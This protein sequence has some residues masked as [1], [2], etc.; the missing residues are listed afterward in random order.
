MPSFRLIS[1]RIISSALTTRPF[2]HRFFSVKLAARSVLLLLALLSAH[3][4]A[5]VTIASGNV[6]DVGKY[7]YRTVSGLT[8]PYNDTAMCWAAAASNVIQYWQ[9][10]YGR[11]AAPDTPQGANATVYT[12]PAG[13]GALEVYN[14]LLQNWTNSSGHPYNGFTW[15]MQGGGLYDKNSYSKPTAGTA[16]GGYYQ[17]I[18]GSV[19]PDHGSDTPLAGAAFY[20]YYLDKGVHEQHYTRANLT[21]L[22]DTLDKAFGTQGQAVA[23]GIF[24]EKTYYSHSISCWGYETDESGTI[25]SL[26]VSDSDDKKYGLTILNLTEGTG[27]DGKPRTYISTDRHNG[28]S[29]DTQ[30]YINQIT[31]IDTPET[32]T[33]DGTPTAIAQKAVANPEA[34]ISGNRIDRSSTLTAA[35]TVSGP[36]TVQGAAM[37]GSTV[38]NAIVL[39]SEKEAMLSINGQAWTGTTPLLHLADGAM[40]LLNG[41]L[42]LQGPGGGVKADGHL[43]I[44]GGDVSV[45]GC[46]SATSGGAMYASDI[47][48]RVDE[49]RISGAQTYIE[50]R[51]A[52]KVN[53]SNNTSRTARKETYYLY[54]A[55]GGAIGAEDSFAII[56]CGDVT[57]NGNRAEG[58]NANGGAAYAQYNAT[59]RDNK[60]HRVTLTN[61]SVAASGCDSYGGAVAGYF[62]D[63]SGNGDVVISGNTMSA[64]NTSEKTWGNSEY[65]GGARVGGGAVAARYFDFQSIYDT[66][67]GVFIYTPATLTMDGNSS[68]SLCN[69]SISATYRGNYSSYSV[70]NQSCTAQGGALFLDSREGYNAG[71]IGAKGSLSHTAGDV[72]LEGNSVS[73][74]SVLRKDDAARGGAL[75]IGRA[76]EM[77][78]TD[79]AGSVSFRGNSASGTT[80]QGGAVYSDGTFS[81]LRNG[82]VSFSGNTAKEGN[83]LYLTENAVTEIAWNE[84]VSFRGA[85]GSTA[86]VNKGTL[87]L[88]ADKG[89]SIDFYGGTLD[90]SEGTLQLGRDAEGRTGAGQLAF[91]SADGSK[92]M[93]INA[94][95]ELEKAKLSVGDIVG[96]GI[97]TTL[98]HQVELQANT[99]LRLSHLN[100][101]A[102]CSISVGQN[103]VTLSDVVIDLSAAS[104]HTMTLQSGTALIFDLQHLI[105]CSLETDNLR[106]DAAGVSG[107]V[108]GDKVL[109]G[110][111]FG[112]DV[113]FVG[114]SSATLVQAGGEQQDIRMQ[115]GIVWFGDAEALPEPAT[116]TLS[117]LALAALAARRR[118]S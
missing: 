21:E 42:S 63:L 98:L 95:A 90:S 57:M 108:L 2:P 81:L 62:V 56:A 111:D 32:A 73:S 69:N 106:F 50:M 86:V 43:Y 25:T 91:H 10:T 65:V 96:G 105:N 8:Q 5:D 76:A 31:F 61:N 107:D 89:R 58:I 55:G 51:G 39:G 78:M 47:D 6:Y 36:L 99:D 97:G 109:V 67:T 4:V 54:Q 64:D 34:S 41:G 46:T 75:F 87:Y 11:Y 59:I 85:D 30:C 28:F 16:T 112:S 15:W 83:D 27:A 103:T 92:S 80:A 93:S 116:A 113:S 100:L 22:R 24:S 74:D 20:D 72:L 7:S 13:T 14:H 49:G 68:V 40:A 66:K 84:Q 3:A 33:I 38:P 52:G 18:F 118:R 110:I 19:I 29:I 114:D 12:Q 94:I 104:Y 77:Q 70:A 60:G 9:D 71:P 1:R 53:L 88:A 45:T 79:N 17:S 101:D 44:H 102:G 48:A 82:A 37:E 23:L 115:N 117:L 26:I 35:V